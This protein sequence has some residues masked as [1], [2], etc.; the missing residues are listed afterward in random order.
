MYPSVMPLE[1]YCILPDGRHE[2][3]DSPPPTPEAV[4]AISPLLDRGGGPVPGAA[5]MTMSLALSGSAAQVLFFDGGELVA[6]CALALSAGEQS[7][8]LWAWICDSLHPAGD[9]RCCEP[10]P[11]PTWAAVAFAPIILAIGPANIFPL[12]ELLRSL[13]A[14]LPGWVVMRN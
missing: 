1:T 8:A 9:T 13:V 6:V 7:R 12:A 10:P 4:H 3:I 14:A 11:A 2:R 5:T